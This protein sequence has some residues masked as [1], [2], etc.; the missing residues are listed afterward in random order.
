MGNNHE[1]G[2]S[3]ISLKVYYLQSADEKEDLLQS[4]QKKGC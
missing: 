1:L 3:G 4:L 2:N